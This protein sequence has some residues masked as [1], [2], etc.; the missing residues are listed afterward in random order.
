MPDFTARSSDIEIMDD[1][2]CAGPILERT[3]IELEII[4]KWLGGNAITIS[5]LKQLL[6]FSYGEEI[7]IVD[8]GCGSGDMLRII[9][10]WGKQNNLRLR[11]IGIDANPFVISF[12]R[13][14][15]I[16]Y[17]HIEFQ[18]LDIFNS[19]FQN[20]K[21]DI[22]IGTLFY[23]HFSNDQL[24]DFFR[25]LKKNVAIGLIINDIHR[26]WLAYHAIRVLTQSFSK[27][28]MVKYDAP[29]SVLRAFSKNE[30]MA[31]LEKAGIG[32][33]EIHWK[34]AFRWQV[35]ARMNKQAA[36]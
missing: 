17:P 30:L 1:L 6:K 35:V 22:V 3:L 11:L 24:T 21:F 20:Q 8:L 2:Q 31:V 23:H 33:F 34:W 10:R 26:H 16:D 25:S 12:A 18:A 27:S 32:N 13:K 36:L 15:L 29:L 28:P 5:S 14:N 4:N 9:D 7:V 19:D